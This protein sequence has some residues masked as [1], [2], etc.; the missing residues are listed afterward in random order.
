MEPPDLFNIF[1]DSV[2][3]PLVSS[4]RARRFGVLRDVFPQGLTHL[5]WADNV[6]LLA[7]DL[8]QFQTMAQMTE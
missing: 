6:Y 2:L 7:A 4:W 3:A 5:V 1:M 8:G